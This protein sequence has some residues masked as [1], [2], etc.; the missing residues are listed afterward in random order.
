MTPIHSSCP[1]DINLILVCKGPVLRPPASTKKGN[2]QQG[3]PFLRD[4][5]VLKKNLMNIFLS[6]S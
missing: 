5:Q 2:D 1:H 4:S 6:A 3:R